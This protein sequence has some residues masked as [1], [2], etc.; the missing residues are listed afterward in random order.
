M[1]SRDSYQHDHFGEIAPFQK[2]G[3]YTS[4]NTQLWQTRGEEYPD[5]SDSF[6][7][8]NENI[9]VDQSTITFI[10]LDPGRSLPWHRDAFYLL[11]QKNPDWK[12]QTL[13]PIRYLIFTQ[14]WD[15]GQFVQ[16]EEK[17]ITQWKSGDCWYFCHETYHLGVNAGLSPF[18]SMQISGFQ[19]ETQ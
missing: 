15:L 14:D 13:I 1:W 4:E 12:D 8:I 10:K 11:K 9:P 16:I 3:Y 17:I 2:T 6:Q 7:H 19:K 5:L 18:V